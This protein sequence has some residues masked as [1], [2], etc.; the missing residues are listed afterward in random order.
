MAM[1]K[2]KNPVATTLETD[3]SKEAPI[4]PA[5]VETTPPEIRRGPGRPRKDAPT[6]PSDAASAAAPRKPG[7][8]RK[9]ASLSSD[10]VLSLAKQV[11]GM[12]QLAALASGI[13]ELIVDENEAVLLSG[14]I[15]KVSEEYGLSLTGKTGA[16]LQLLAAAGMIYAPRLVAVAKRV[17]AQ[18]QQRST[19]SLSIV[20]GGT[21]G[22]PA[23]S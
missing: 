14:A 4:T 17:K 15:A 20:E 5:P 1:S 8:P 12:H 9:S 19:P 23:A 21:H 18:K 22:D 10:D 11:Q 6:S 13:P 16:M 2:E 7:R 3:A